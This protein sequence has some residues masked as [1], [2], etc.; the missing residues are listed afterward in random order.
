MSP[1]HPAREGVIAGIIG[2]AT[3]AFWFFV[4]DL[5]AGRPLFTPAVLGASLF[6]VLG[7]GAERNLLQNVAFYTAFHVAAFVVVGVVAAAMVRAADRR[8]SRTMLFIGFFVAFELGFTVLTAVFARSPL[9]GRIAWYQFGAANVIAALLM[10]RHI[11]RTYHPP[12]DEQ[13]ARWVEAG[14]A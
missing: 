12:V 13:W 9:F 8:P 2:A 10:G 5:I 1:R 4:V 14:H 3:V 7:L 6:D 11:W